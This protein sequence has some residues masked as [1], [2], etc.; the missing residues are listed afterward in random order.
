MRSIEESK[1]KCPYNI[2][3]LNCNS[4]CDSAKNLLSKIFYQIRT[5]NDQ[6]V[7]FENYNDCIQVFHT[8]LKKIFNYSSLSMIKSVEDNETYIDFKIDENNFD[9]VMIFLK[10]LYRMYKRCSNDYEQGFI[11]DYFSTILFGDSHRLTIS[12]KM[13]Q[14]FQLFIQNLEQIQWREDNLSIHNS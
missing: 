9:I 13:K 5:S 12:Q 7:L 10:H 3:L 1:V 8:I 6:I 11:L 14:I 2:Q 4:M